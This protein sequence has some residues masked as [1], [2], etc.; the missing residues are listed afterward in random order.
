M[1]HVSVE[2]AG[3]DGLRL[4]ESAPL[5]LLTF[6][7]PTFKQQSGVIEEAAA[8]YGDFLTLGFVDILAHPD[9]AGRFAVAGLPVSLLLRAGR[10]VQ[11]LSGVQPKEAY[12]RALNRA[13]AGDPIW[14]LRALA[15][16]GEPLAERSRHWRA[17]A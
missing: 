7:T 14:H 2:V 3:E 6:Y 9:I 10:V 1:A 4:V 16:G 13:L 12:A 5:A 8:E 15:A 11:R 17:S